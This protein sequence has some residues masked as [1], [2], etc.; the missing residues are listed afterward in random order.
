MPFL[1]PGGRDVTWW[2]WIVRELTPAFGGFA[3]FVLDPDDLLESPEVREGL[4]K[5][6][7]RVCQWSGDRADLE[8]WTEVAPS[9]RPLVVLKPNQQTH[10]VTEVLADAVILDTSIAKVFR[11]IEADIVRAVPR[12]HWDSLFTLQSFDRPLRTMQESAIA[13]ARAVYGIDPLFA[14]IHGWHAAIE[15]VA[16]SAEALP[17]LIVTEIVPHE[18]GDVRMALTDVATARL[19]CPQATTSQPSNKRTSE[20]AGTYV[21]KPGEKPSVEEIA[22]GTLNAVQMLEAGLRFGRLCAAGLERERR[23]EANEGFLGWLRSNYD[24]AMTS[25]NPLVLKLHTLIDSYVKP[26]DKVMF[27]VVDGMGVEAWAAIR[28]VWEHERGLVVTAELAAFSIIPT[29]TSWARRAIFE[30]VLPPQFSPGDHSVSLER[31]LWSKRV[32]NGAY[33]SIGERTGLFD[34][35]Y[36]GKSIAL[37]DISWDK[38]GH[39]IDPLTETIAEAARSW[40]AKC[41]VADI[42]REATKLGYRVVLTADHGQAVGK[43]IG[44]PNMGSAI[45][46]RS[47]RCLIFGSPA[48]LNAVSNPGIADFHSIAAGHG[49]HIMYAKFGESFHHGEAEYVSHGGLSIE[50][51]IVPV[52]EFGHE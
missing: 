50:E 33:F 14:A 39:A 10:L 13:V 21:T 52:L 27:V 46:S 44:M 51:V 43:G 31:Q 28:D 4:T 26:K 30:R 15:R 6:G 25:H 35:M 20:R 7:V 47:K 41:A 5:A 40:A 29:I 22:S 37:V 2:E 45:E 3:S 23:A 1:L 32:A 34:T 16:I 12:E 49:A 38:R 48:G 36:Q 8:Q 9:D 24:L 17:E 19:R 18:Y 42:I 11:K